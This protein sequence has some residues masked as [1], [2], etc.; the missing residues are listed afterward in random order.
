MEVITEMKESGWVPTERAYMK[1]LE[2]I[3]G[4]KVRSIA[5]GW[6]GRIAGG[7]RASVIRVPA[8]FFRLK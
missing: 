5:C 7:A 3:R 1:V 2:T 8:E 6:N 4:T